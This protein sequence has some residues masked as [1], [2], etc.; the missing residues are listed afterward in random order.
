[1]APPWPEIYAQDTERRHEFSS[2]VEEF[3]RLESALSD[4]G[5]DIII[6]PKIAVAQRADVLLGIL[7][8]PKPGE[9]RK[10]GIPGKGS[11]G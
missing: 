8:N 10:A 1:M 5:Y 4:L 9:T 7:A 11:T 6:L 3:E 2:A